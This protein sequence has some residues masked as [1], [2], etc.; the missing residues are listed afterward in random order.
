MP[1]LP[2]P[3]LQSQTTANSPPYIFSTP[4]EADLTYLVIAWF[5]ITE[6]ASLGIFPL[7]SA[8]ETARRKE[9]S[10]FAR[11]FKN[12]FQHFNDEQQHANLWCQALLD[13]TG[14][15]PEVVRRVKLPR[16]FLKIML[17]S[18]GKPHSVL[19][20]AVDCLAFEV[21]M[22]AL[23][24]VMEPR[25]AYPPVRAILQVIIR[26]EIA[27][28]GFGR[29]Y[30]AELFELLSTRQR[31]LIAFRYWGNMLGV[32]ITISPLLKALNRHQALSQ[33]E[34][35]NK[36]AL[37]SDDT[38]ILGNYRLLPKGLIRF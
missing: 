22:Q 3:E 14:Q 11:F 19:N 29:G 34:F 12:A 15:Y 36:V 4:A 35:W 1:D 13:F 26:D 21:V 30:L 17:K 23:Y 38:G 9:P 28:T 16:Q 6:S 18:I 27:H 8:L 20:F 5:A 31:Y 33:A 2:P 10:Y 25:L 7:L 37:Y 24:D 32:L